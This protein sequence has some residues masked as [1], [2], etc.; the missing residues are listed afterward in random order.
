[1]LRIVGDDVV[2][3]G[4]SADGDHDITAGIDGVVLAV[5]VAR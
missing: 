5:A 2:G 4:K 3:L 1:V